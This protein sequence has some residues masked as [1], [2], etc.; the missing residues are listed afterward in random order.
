M[1][2]S[3]TWCLMV[4]FSH[5]VSCRKWI[6]KKFPFFS[7]CLEMYYL[8]NSKIN[9]CQFCLKQRVYCYK[10]LNW[11]LSCLRIKS[12]YPPDHFISIF[13]I[14]IFLHWIFLFSKKTNTIL[15]QKIFYICTGYWE[16]LQILNASCLWFWDLLRNLH[17]FCKCKLASLVFSMHLTL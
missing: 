11:F 13:P 5:D 7:W 15:I 14:C 12:I 1:C 9:I 8:P 4:T 2:N 16:L 17:W 10:R 6:Q 3:R